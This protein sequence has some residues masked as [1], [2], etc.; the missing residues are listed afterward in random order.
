LI[1]EYTTNNGNTWSTLGTNGLGTNWY[2]NVS[3]GPNFTG[4]GWD[5][6][7]GGWIRC[8]Y[9]VALLNGTPSV[10]FRFHFE[11]D[12]FGNAEGA[13]IDDF[14]LKPPVPNDAGVKRII[15]PGPQVNAGANIVPTVVV[16]NF[17]NNVLTTFRYLYRY[18]KSW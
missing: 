15:S 2:N 7:T 13:A 8:E 10:R 1:L 14:C 4:P 5:G 6:N 3:T 12:F 16:K 9:P 18:I 17:V 11:S